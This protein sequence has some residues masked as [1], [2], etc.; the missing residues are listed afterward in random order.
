MFCFKCGSQQADDARFCGICGTGLAGALAAQS[1]QPVPVAPVVGT[2]PANPSPAPETRAADA[3][4]TVDDWAVTCTPP[5]DDGD[6]RFEAKVRGEFHGATAAHVARLSWIAFDSTGTIPLLQ[7]DSTL[8]QDLDDEDAVEI[9]AGGYGKL[10]EVVAPAACQIRGQVVLYPGEKQ[11]PWTIPLP[12]AGQAGGEGP[13]WP[14]MGAEI[15]GWRLTCSD[16]SEE[17][18]SYR[19]CIVSRNVG[20]RPL[21]AVTFRLR[22]KNRKGD[23]WSTEYLFVERLAPGETRSVETGLYLS[24]RAK[25]RRGAVVEFVA[26]VSPQETVSPLAAVAPTLLLTEAQPDE[27]DEDDDAHADHGVDEGGDVIKT[28]EMISESFEQ[29]RQRYSSRS[30]FVAIYCPAG[31]EYDRE[32]IGAHLFPDSDWGCVDPPGPS[33]GFGDSGEIGPNLL[34]KRRIPLSSLKNRPGPGL[35]KSR[36]V[37]EAYVDGFFV[38]DGDEELL[39]EVPFAAF[40]ERIERGDDRD[41]VEFVEFEPG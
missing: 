6:V 34:E 10:G 13:A 8:T 28:V 24:E 21:A 11:A 32:A 7:G 22:L 25:A 15:T 33:T 3:H 31:L 17:N 35:E 20:T 9:E 4:L 40:V 2:S 27:A 37:L 41:S 26:I 1:G 19:L 29:K 5:D 38:V 16:S 12:E 23:V 36:A 14:D 30:A 18:V 39:V